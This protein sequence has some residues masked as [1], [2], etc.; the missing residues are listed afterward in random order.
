MLGFLDYSIPPLTLEERDKPYTGINLLGEKGLLTGQVPVGDGLFIETRPA[1]WDETRGVVELGGDSP[2]S[3]VLRNAGVG[4]EGLHDYVS[5]NAVWGASENGLYVGGGTYLDLRG[6]SQQDVNNLNDYSHL[7]E[8]H[9]MRWVEGNGGNWSDW[10][11][12]GALGNNYRTQ[13]SLT[14]IN[15]AGTVSVGFSAVGGEQTPQGVAYTYGIRSRAAFGL[16]KDG[17]DPALEELKPVGS[18]VLAWPWDVDEA[19]N[20]VGTSLLDAQTAPIYPHAVEWPAES[21]EARL[22]PNLRGEEIPVKEAVS[23]ARA[24][25]RNG[26]YAVGYDTQWVEQEGGGGNSGYYNPRAVVWVKNRGATET[27]MTL[28]EVFDLNARVPEGW[29]FTSAHGVNDEGIILVH[30]HRRME[31]GHWEPRAA[32]LLPIEIVD[33]DKKAVTKLKVGKMAETGVLTGTG[34]SGTLN[35]DKDSDRF[36]VRI[37]GA[38]GMGTVS[39]KVATVE[40]PDASYNDDE[41]EIDMQVDGNDLITKSML[42]VSDDVDDDH[43]VDGIA[44]D[45]KN[46][47]THKIQLGG[48]FQIKSIKIGGTEHQADI[49]TTAPA[50]KT[51][52]VKL[53]NCKSGIPGFTQPILTTAQVELIERRTKERFAQCGIEITMSVANGIS[54]G[55]IGYLSNPPTWSGPGSTMYFP[56]QS[57]DFFLDPLMPVAPDEVPVYAVGGIGTSPGDPLGLATVPAVMSSSDISAGL[58]NRVLLGRG[59]N[60]FVIAHELLHVLMNAHHA[61]GGP[62]ATEHGDSRMLWHPTS[63]TGSITDTKRISVRQAEAIVGTTSIPPESPFPQ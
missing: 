56:P 8:L 10:D 18:A 29:E 42:L 15:Q 30:G 34:S 39:I 55:L 6:F 25:S 7:S 62:Y 63:N 32:F 59:W 33:K 58:G 9:G 11:E 50:T 45:A 12:V 24:I 35:I 22:L 44:D 3:F 41:T 26:R 40:N 14:A 43:K 4:V 31:N 38:A 16:E 28:W 23:H 51:V 21:G 20:A 53:Y 57:R 60:S 48:K 2:E 19:G 47:R 17:G 13:S 46:D 37:P 5:L 52:K 61:T 36:F 27:D 1:V 54:V 49:R